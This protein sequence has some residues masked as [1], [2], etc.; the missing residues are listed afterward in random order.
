MEINVGIIEN[1]RKMVHDPEPEFESPTKKARAEVPD[2]L[3][4]SPA[5]RDSGDDSPWS[6][7]S[8]NPP[9]LRRRVQGLG[10]ICGAGLIILGMGFGLCREVV[11]VSG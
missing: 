8:S 1:S 4:T 7:R 10:Y 3:R 5:S 9:A 2:K 11:R 6:R